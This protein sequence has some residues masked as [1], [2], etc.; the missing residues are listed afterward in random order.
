MKVESVAISKLRADPENVRRHDQAN[1]ESIKQSLIEFGQ[2]YPIVAERPDIVRKGSG[3][4]V[5]AAELGW[6]KIDVVWTDLSG[7]KAKAYAIKDNATSDSSYFDPD[8]LAA[9]YVDLGESGIDLDSLGFNSA[10]SEGEGEG[11]GKDVKLVKHS[12]LPPPVMAWAL[13]GI[14]TVRFGEIAPLVERVGKIPGVL[15]ETVISG[16]ANQD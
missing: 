7:A 12:T 1:I 2:Q 13:I 8:A 16:A 6:T 14:P 11:E 5:A 9:A 10:T 4:L 15:C 3:T